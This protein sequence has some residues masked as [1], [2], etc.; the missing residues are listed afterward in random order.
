[1][2][3][4]N[5]IHKVCLFQKKIENKNQKYWKYYKEIYNEQISY[6]VQ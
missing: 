6:K 1:M 3:D 4:R 5:R 2:D